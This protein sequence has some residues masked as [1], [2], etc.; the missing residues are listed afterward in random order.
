MAWEVFSGDIPFA[1]Q[2]ESEITAQHLMVA[3]DQVPES[4]HALLN[5]CW[6]DS[7]EDRMTF[8]AAQKLFPQ[9]GIGNE[10][11]RLNGETK[12]TMQNENQKETKKET[13]IEMAPEQMAREELRK[14]KI[15]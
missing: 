11:G 2:M 4:M 6:I 14:K 12:A 13:K 8:M 3:L 7:P 5:G 1:G 9:N 15:S 10:N